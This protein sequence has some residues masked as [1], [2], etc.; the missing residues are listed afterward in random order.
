MFL[1]FWAN[2]LFVPFM[3]WGFRTIC[4]FLYTIYL[5]VFSLFVSIVDT[6]SS[7]LWGLGEFLLKY[8]FRP[9]GDLENFC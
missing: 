2:N 4:I 1:G 6:F 3:F 8:S 7:S 5:L 9:Y